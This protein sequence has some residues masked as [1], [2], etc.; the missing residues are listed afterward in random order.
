[1][2]R[3]PFSESAIPSFDQAPSLILILGDHEFFVEEA[4]E[5]A[6]E[7]LGRDG[8]EEIRFDEDTPAESISDALLNRSLFS[9]RRLVQLDVSRLLGTDSPGDL[10]DRA[11]ESWRQ[12]TPAG[13]REAWRRA[14]GLLSALDL[15]GDAQETAEAAARRLRRKGDAAELAEILRELP[16]QRGAPAAVASALRLLLARGND[17]V[18][19]L[20]TA[21]DAPR[22]VGLVQEIERG[23]LVLEA[24]IGEDARG[25]LT[26]LARAR[27]RDLDVTIEPDAISRLIVQTDSQPRA[28]ASELDK[29]LAWAGPGGRVR[30]ED[31][32]LQVEDE[33]GEDLYAFYDAIGRRDAAESLARLERIFDGRVVRIGAREV[34]TEDYWEVRFFGMLAGEVRRMLLLR[35]RAEQKGIALDASMSYPAFQARVLPALSEPVAPFG[36]SPFE[37]ARGG[38]K[39]YLWYKAAL[40]AAR[41]RAAELR[42][43][44]AAAAD[45]DVKLKSSAP[46]LE[47]ISAYVGRL[48]AGGK[49]SGAPAL[50]RSPGGTRTLT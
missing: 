26:R 46:P 38:V 43:A 36:H 18:V 13:R 49:R 5:R 3:R 41:Y 20:L 17:G 6:R 23:G 8:V 44:L 19:A 10:L 7:V 35:A 40:R 29:L 33:A 50:P 27:S 15:S 32:S 30:A 11:L 47:T 16:E 12:G 1:M 48:I 37:D 34:D 9:P 45:V 28:F 2:P 4:A 25:V 22:G 39:P 42:S 24:S 21:A 14:R 31:V